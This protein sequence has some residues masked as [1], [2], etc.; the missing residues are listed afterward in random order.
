MFELDSVV[1]TLLR[2][3]GLASSGESTDIYAGEDVKTDYPALADKI[4]VAV[5]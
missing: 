2:A 5:F 1:G 3:L 4:F